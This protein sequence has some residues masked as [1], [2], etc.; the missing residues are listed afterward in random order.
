[1]NSTAIGFGTVDYIMRSVDALYI[2]VVVLAI[3][4]LLA[5]RGNALLLPRVAGG[6]PGPSSAWIAAA[7][8][9]SGAARR[10]R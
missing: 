5:L 9:D 3:V 1:M 6:F 2:P 4:S 10:S 7:A 8:G